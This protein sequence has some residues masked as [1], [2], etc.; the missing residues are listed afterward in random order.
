MRGGFF[1]YCHNPFGKGCPPLRRNAAMVCLNGGFLAFLHVPPSAVDN[2]EDWGGVNFSVTN[3]TSNLRV[4]HQS[5]CYRDPIILQNDWHHALSSLP[6]VFLQHSL[7]LTMSAVTNPT[8][9]HIH[10][11]ANA[12]GNLPYKASCQGRRIKPLKYSTEHSRLLYMG[13]QHPIISKT[14]ITNSVP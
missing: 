12:G 9:C 5:P 7:P 3:K 8:Q 11:N 13:P 6:I 10:K 14:P 4:D 2:N 1:D